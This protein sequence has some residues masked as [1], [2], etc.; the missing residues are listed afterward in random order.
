MVL[1]VNL[2]IFLLHEVSALWTLQLDLFQSEI[3]LQWAV[4]GREI[5]HN[6]QLF[7]ES[8]DCIEMR[9]E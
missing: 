8:A 6:L 5:F 7:T 1:L 3:L 2:E 9:K 4:V